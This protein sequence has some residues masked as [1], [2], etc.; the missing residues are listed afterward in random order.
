MPSEH[1][2][3]CMRAAAVCLAALSF[4]ASQG[5]ISD[6][7]F[8]YSE[9]GTAERLRNMTSDARNEMSRKLVM[10]ERTGKGRSAAPAD[11]ARGGPP[12][13]ISLDLRNAISIA[14]TGKL[15]PGHPQADL[16]RGS[17]ESE[18]VKGLR[19][20]DAGAFPAGNRAF[21]S[22]M[23]SLQNSMTGL[24]TTEH[25]WDPQIS[26]TVSYLYSNSRTT[27]PHTDVSSGSLGAGIS[28]KLPFGGSAGLNV[29]TGQSQNH[30]DKKSRSATLAVSGSVSQP[31]LKGFGY[32]QARESVVQARRSMVY[33]I[34]D[35]EQY[36]QDFTIDV[37]RRYYDLIRQ[38]QVVKNNRR[39][40]EQASFLLSQTRQLY[41]KLGE[42][43]TIDVIRSELSEQQAKDSLD[44]AERAFEE[45]T[46]AFK[47]FLGL[48]PATGIEMR[49]ETPVFK[50]VDFEPVS[51]EK[52]A[53]N[54]RLDLLNS[55][56]A[57]EDSARALDFANQ[58][59]L[60]SLDFVLNFNFGHPSAEDYDEIRLRTHDFSA[61]LTLEIPFDRIGARNSLRTQTTALMQALRAFTG[62]IDAVRRQVGSDMRSLRRLKRSI[63]SQARQIEIA[64]RKE[65]KALIDFQEGEIS[66]R[67]LV[68]AQE[69]LR[70]AENS[71]IE[72]QVNYE[73]ARV[74]LLR[75][76]GILKLDE[77]GNIVEE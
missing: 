30:M 66:N 39:A 72:T 38:K 36:R 9:D 60:P 45:A 48:D 49:D 28:Q 58:N 75:D 34:R 31:L 15:R 14:A 20:G 53:L 51:C 59:L 61:G 11:P 1:Y 40:Y 32:G 77:T 73:I 5:C 24:I 41:E 68:E 19:D 25:E 54:N 50:D 37:M 62:E 63:G 26:G 18:L 43:T 12:P 46:D 27:G 65:R 22:R 4:A 29:S 17:S 69:E 33:A 23:E 21:M 13:V 8:G 6:L 55:F 3:P 52:A 7:M 71:L 2:D 44:E 70:D 35:F 42:K 74:Q 76:V 56:Q 67:D 16:V 57:L 64:R 10:P 47:L